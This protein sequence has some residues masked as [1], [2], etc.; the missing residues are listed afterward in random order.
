MQ[1]MRNCEDGGIV[2]EEPEVV[3]VENLL[4]VPPCDLD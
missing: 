4:I 3:L 2:E 1:P